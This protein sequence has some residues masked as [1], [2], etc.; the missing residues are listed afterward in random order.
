MITVMN[1]ACAQSYPARTI[2]IVA[3]A[4]GGPTDIVARVIAQNIAAPL[5]RTVIVDNRAVAVMAEYVAR[6]PPDGYTLLVSGANLWLSPLMRDKSP[7]D[8]VKDFAPLS[9]AVQEPTILVVH[10]SVPARSVR[11]FVAL[12]K[13]RPG[14]LN[15]ASG[16]TGSSNHLAAE[17]FKS[18]AGVNLVRVTYKGGGPA[19]M[20]LIAGQVQLM[21]ASPGVA[22]QHVKSGR[23]RALAVTSAQPSALAPDLPTV[24]ATGLPGYESATTHGFFVPAKAPAAL[25]NRLNSEMLRVL[26]RNEVKEKFLAVGVEVVTS[27]PQEFAAVIKSEMIK[28][29]KV[30]KDAGNRAD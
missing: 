22:G 24:A 1:P 5:G 10:P 26:N 30:I 11:E 19:V 21:F 4:A 14:D 12:A 8:P 23:L 16:A 2:R 29:G 25:V 28:L 17:L 27:S 7:Y 18:M 15:Y 9:L 6:E 3:A 20:D 13:S